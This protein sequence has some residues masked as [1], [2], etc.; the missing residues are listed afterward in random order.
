MSH[1][2]KLTI[3]TSTNPDDLLN[4]I[5][6]LLAL[7]DTTAALAVVGMVADGLDSS[8]STLGYHYYVI[9][10]NWEVG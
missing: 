6:D 2:T 4:N 10:T 9:I 5:N 3:Y 1:K 8:V 7:G